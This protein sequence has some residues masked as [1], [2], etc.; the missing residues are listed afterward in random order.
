MKD[1]SKERIGKRNKMKNGM[2]A[3]II[4]YIKYDD[5]SVRFDDGT[6]VPHRRY[7]HFKNGDI[8]CPTKTISHIGET[9]IHGD[10]T[11][12]I[13]KWRNNADIDFIDDTGVLYEH[14]TYYRFKHCSSF[15]VKNTNSYNHHIVERKQMNYGEFA[16]I[17]DFD[18]KT[19]KI[20]VK[21]DDGTIRENLQ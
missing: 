5:I 21:F 1:I 17:I 11:Y 7:D 13:I 10:K 14:K 6:V 12:T 16:T 9:A 2:Y 18:M 3:E 8:V 20:T 19:K 15:R 4:D